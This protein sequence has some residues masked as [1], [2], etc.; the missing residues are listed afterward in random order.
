[1]ISKE[2]VKHVAKLARLELSSD[3]EEKFSKDLNS[4]L[5]YI[6]Q[7]K[8]VETE[9]IEPMA[10]AAGLENILRPDENPTTA[11]KEDQE[12]LIKQAPSH[13]DGYVK[14]KAVLK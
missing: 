14:V 3:Q 13:K 7:L 8:E 6:D 9:N 12:R 4:V 2:E 10:H 5:N 11:S 1:M